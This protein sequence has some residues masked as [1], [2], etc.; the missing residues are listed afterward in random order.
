M[1]T[2]VSRGH[3]SRGADTR[4]VPAAPRIM[5]ASRGTG[6]QRALLADLAVLATVAAVVGLFAVSPETLE[7]RGFAYM[8]SGGGILSKF[9]PSTL[10]A[11]VALGLRCLATSRP[12][13]T[14]WRVAT[15]DTGAVLLLAGVA[16]AGLYATMISKTP[17]TPLVDTFALPVLVFLLLRDLDAAVVRWL[18]LL[19]ALILCANAV[20]AM[21]E[22]LRDWHLVTIDVPEDA[23]ADPTR[24]DATFDWRAQLAADWRATALLGHPLVNG[25]IAGSFILC[26]A[27]P[28]SRWLPAFVRAPLLLL[29]FVSLSAFGARAALVLTA[30]LGGWMGLGQ[31]VEAISRG[32]RVKP[33]QIA[34]G[35]LAISLL[36]GAGAIL[37][38]SGFLD[39]TI[40]RFGNDEG[41]ATTRI[42][43]FNLFQ[44]FSL[45][46]LLLGPDQDVAATQQRL[47]GLEFGIE[48]SWIGL[49]LIYGLV[50]TTILVVGLLAFSWS[51]IKACGR[52]TA[53]V[54]IFYFILISVSASMSGKT[55]SFA[56]AIILTSVFLRKDE[57]RRPLWSA[58]RVR[59]A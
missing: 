7:S 35:L 29:Q 13:R 26:L 54:L 8:T 40:E 34:I 47:E 48:S 58:K 42:T 28:G 55:T 53:L 57:R 43:M 4:R 10:I 51:V 2:D 44:P 36:I 46:D 30:A 50:V 39:H 3:G 9:H 37:L 5:S 14:G 27:A 32:A 31:A 6:S 59:L 21:I 38:Q 1:T 12:L 45:S 19:I 24:G 25:L 49:V 16:I 17:V 18:A 52:G 41:S 33:A 56:M 20:I 23:T 22:F 11:I 15:G